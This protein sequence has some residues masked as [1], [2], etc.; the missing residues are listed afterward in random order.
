M[1]LSLR[2]AAFLVLETPEVFLIFQPFF[3]FV[4]G[5]YHFLPRFFFLG[6]PRLLP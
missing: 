1:A 3:D 2:F 5:I 4:I 6:R